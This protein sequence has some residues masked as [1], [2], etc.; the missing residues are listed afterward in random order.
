MLLHRR[1]AVTSTATL[2]TRY[3]T[4]RHVQ[5]IN[6]CTLFPLFF[7]LPSPSLSSPKKQQCGVAASSAHL[8]RAQ[9]A[10]LT[11]RLQ[12]GISLACLHHVTLPQLSLT[13]LQNKAR[14]SG[15]H[16]P[17]PKRPLQFHP[18]EHRLQTRNTPAERASQL[19]GPP[20]SPCVSI[21]CFLSCPALPSPSPSLSQ[22]LRTLP[23]EQKRHRPVSTSHCWATWYHRKTQAFAAAFPAAK[24]LSIGGLPLPPP[25]REIGPPS[26]THVCC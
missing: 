22:T 16:L 20:N 3:S 13:R 15:A 11:V 23:L 6:Q 12:I 14:E 21:S 5:Y 25:K 8:C 9:I 4:C 2:T 18:N 1:V 17:L 26:P 7:H 19:P 24:L 10:Q